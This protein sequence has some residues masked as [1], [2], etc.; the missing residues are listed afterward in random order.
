MKGKKGV[1]FLVRCR[2]EKKKRT[3]AEN[4]LWITAFDYSVETTSNSSLFILKS[5][6][7]MMTFL[8]TIDFDEGWQF[9]E[10]RIMKLRRIIEGHHEPQFDSE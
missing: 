4:G 9:L 1:S 8:R 2:S 10:T 5:R 6:S 7:F 3:R